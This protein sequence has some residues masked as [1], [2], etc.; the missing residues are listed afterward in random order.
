MDMWSKCCING[1]VQIRQHLFPP[2]GTQEYCP[3]EVE[4]YGKYHGEPATVWS[5]GIILFEILLSR[6]PMRRDLCK[7]TDHTWTRDGLSQG[8][9]IIPE[10]NFNSE[11]Y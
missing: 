6:F 4:M 5:L 10:D 8:E 1:N 2:P 11:S 9:I 7:M 3:P